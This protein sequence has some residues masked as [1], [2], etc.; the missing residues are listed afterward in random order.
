METIGLGAVVALGWSDGYDNG[1]VCAVHEDGTIDI[2]RPYIH[3]NDFSMSA[4]EGSSGVICY[5][6]S[7]TCKRVDPKRVKLIRKGPT[8]R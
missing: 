3:A 5:I 7:E 6:G 1:T 2:F 8:L 4:G